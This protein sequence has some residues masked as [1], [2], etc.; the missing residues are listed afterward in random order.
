VCEPNYAQGCLFN[1]TS[2][3]KEDAVKKIVLITF[4]TTLLLSAT[5]AFAWG[6]GN[7]GGDGD[8]RHGCQNQ[9]GEYGDG[10]GFGGDLSDFSAEDAKSTLDNT[11]KP[12]FKGYAFG[13]IETFDTHRG[14][15]LYL[16]RAADNSGN[17]FV[18]FF[19]PNGRV[20]GPILEDDLSDRRGRG[21]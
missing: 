8:G 11:L 9:R 6:H 10:G 20:K 7:W 13:E 19:G 16:V 5:S 18:F 21:F 2:N 1:I 15:S 4:V 14:V 17:K 3:N 12:K